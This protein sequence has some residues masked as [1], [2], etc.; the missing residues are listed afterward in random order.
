[1]RSP[2]PTAPLAAWVAE[3]RAALD[4]LRRGDAAAPRARLDAVRGALDAADGLMGAL[5]RRQRQDAAARDAALGQALAAAQAGAAAARAA[6]AA[7]EDAVRRRT[8]AAAAAQAALLRAQA[9]LA[10]LEARNARLRAGLAAREAE[11]EALLGSR[12]WKLTAPLRTVARRLR[13]GGPPPAQP[14][15]ET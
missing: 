13:R 2:R 1:M 8:A 15:T 6:A 5:A 10:E 4:D 3:S 12:S 7:A 14:E 11:R 9:A